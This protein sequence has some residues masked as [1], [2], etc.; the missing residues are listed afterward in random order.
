MYILAV[1]L[2]WV[3]LCNEYNEDSCENISAPSAVRQLVA[4]ETNPAEVTLSWKSPDQKNGVIVIYMI[5]FRGVKGVSF[6]HLGLC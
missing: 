2:V 3:Q 5:N 1:K 4:M 6:E